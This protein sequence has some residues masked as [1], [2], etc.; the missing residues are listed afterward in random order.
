[1]KKNTL[2][3]HNIKYKILQKLNDPRSTAEQVVLEKAK[4]SNKILVS[5]SRNDTTTTITIS[6]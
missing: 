4:L 2:I 6:N 3:L 5:L 1:M